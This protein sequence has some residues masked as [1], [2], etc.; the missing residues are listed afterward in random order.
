[1]H[2]L[3]DPEITIADR[4]PDLAV[5]FLLNPIFGDHVRHAHPQSS[6]F[7]PEE[8]CF[9]QPVLIRF[10]G[11]LTGNHA[12]YLVPDIHSFFTHPTR[13][14]HVFHNLWKIYNSDVRFEREPIRDFA[15]SSDGLDSEPQCSTFPKPLGHYFSGSYPPCFQ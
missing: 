15:N 2:D 4:G 12:S 6:T 7:R 9:R 13:F 11:D 8:K 3:P 1:M 10:R 5:V 14:A